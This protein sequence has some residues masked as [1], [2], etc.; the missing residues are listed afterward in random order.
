MY[1]GHRPEHNGNA[2]RGQSY[3]AGTAALDDGA[4][5]GL[6]ATARGQPHYRPRALLDGTQIYVNNRWQHYLYKRC[7]RGNYGPL[8]YC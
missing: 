6:P 8:H 1:E 7:T 4:G 2:R 5:C 3:G